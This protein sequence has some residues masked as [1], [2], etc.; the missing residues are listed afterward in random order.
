MKTFNIDGF[1]DSFQSIT[2]T[3]AG[4][5]SMSETIVQGSAGYSTPVNLSSATVVHDQLFLI[6]GKGQEHALKLRDWDVACRTGHRMTLI[7]KAKKTHNPNLYFELT[8]MN[9]TR[10]RYM[11]VHNHT[12][13]ST[14][15]NEYLIKKMTRPNFLVILAISLIPCYFLLNYFLNSSIWFTAIIGSMIAIIIWRNLSVIKDN[16]RLKEALISHARDEIQ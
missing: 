12:T 14:Q 11:A 6:D 13:N 8:D 16:N 4:K 3:I 15:Y 9:N 7:W 5:N 2:G 10:E 1:K